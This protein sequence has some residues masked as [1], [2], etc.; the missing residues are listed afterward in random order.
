VAE[1]AVIHKIR[2]TLTSRNVPSLEK[3]MLLILD[4]YVLVTNIECV[5]I[6]VLR[7]GWCC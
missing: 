5:L 3:G 4:K 2:I 1:E 7:V 6:S